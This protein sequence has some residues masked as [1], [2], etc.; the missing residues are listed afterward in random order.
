MFS[1]VEILRQQLFKVG[2]ADGKSGYTLF[3][4][5]NLLDVIYKGDVV[6]AENEVLRRIHIG[7]VQITFV[8]QV[9]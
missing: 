9:V 1:V 2:I 4:G 5:R 3:V 6:L 8:L 7:G